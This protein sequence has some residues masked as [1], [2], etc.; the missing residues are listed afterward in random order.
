VKICLTCDS[1]FRSE[2]WTCP[3][4][5]AKP[6]APD[7]IPR[8]APELAESD[9]GF[10]PA[11]FKVLAALEEQSFWFRSRNRLITWALSTDFPTARNF[12]E[13][14]CGT[15]YVLRGLSEAAPQLEL[16]GSEL[17]PAGLALARRRVAARLHQMDA[18]RIPYEE[19]FDVIGAFDVLEHITEDEQVLAQMQQAVR[20]GGGIMLTVPQHRWLWSKIDERARHA[21]RYRRSDLVGK[22]RRSGFS[23]RR[24]TSFVTLLLPTMAVARL[25]PRR[26]GS[27][28]D[29]RTELTCTPAVN[30]LFERVMS[31]ELRLIRRG[32]SLPWGGSLL[33]TAVRD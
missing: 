22:V 32:L 31:F 3:E 11:A 1:R 9:E 18:R 26:Q 12:L 17:H 28:L 7:G 24:V 25:L 27:Q 4:C 16:T 23:I 2:G 30:S 29:R 15:G 21:R 8:F 19:A 13:V 20:P 33:L 5:G 6:E 14:G 10:D